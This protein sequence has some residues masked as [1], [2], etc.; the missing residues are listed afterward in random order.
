MCPQINL[1]DHWINLINPFL[2]PWYSFI[3][4]PW[5]FTRELRLNITEL[6]ENFI[7]ISRNMKIGSLL[8]PMCN[9]IHRHMKKQF[10]FNKTNLRQ[11]P[12][13]PSMSPNSE[14][15]EKYL[16]SLL[17]YLTSRH[18]NYLVWVH[19]SSQSNYSSTSKM[20]D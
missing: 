10:V 1:L 8:L 4:N 9:L 15:G 12:E 2:A 7:K 18:T 11:P 3:G 20:F 13:H 17:T 14:N 6:W 16:N 5:R 19:I